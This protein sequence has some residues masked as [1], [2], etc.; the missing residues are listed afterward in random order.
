MDNGINLIF[1]NSPYVIS[2]DGNFILFFK[3]EN[4]QMQINLSKE[5]F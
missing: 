5:D 3:D 1:T 4:K 2:N